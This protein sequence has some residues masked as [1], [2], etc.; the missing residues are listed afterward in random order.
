MDPNRPAAPSGK[1]I[2]PHPPPP[3]LNPG[4]HVFSNHSDVGS[5]MF[6]EMANPGKKF[7]LITGVFLVF[8]ILV[9]GVG[10][11]LSLGI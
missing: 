8:C 9:V 10:K 7:M 2:F 5:T 1:N 3:S 11:V 4:P 6:R